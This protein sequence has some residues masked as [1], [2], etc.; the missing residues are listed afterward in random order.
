MHPVTEYAYGL[1]TQI[2]RVVEEQNS[3]CD[4]SGG[5]QILKTTKIAPT[6]VHLWNVVTTCQNTPGDSS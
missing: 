2:I 6:N 1:V 4:S 3:I 5:G